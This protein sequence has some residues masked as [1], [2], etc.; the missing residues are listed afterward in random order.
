MSDRVKEKQAAYDVVV[1]GGGL[2]GI[3][4]AIAASSA[5]LTR[6]ILSMGEGV[7]EYISKKIF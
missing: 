1:V 6:T 5:R 3:C 7:G 4:A 2:S